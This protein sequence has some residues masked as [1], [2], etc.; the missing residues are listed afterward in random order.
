MNTIAWLIDSTLVCVVLF[1]LAHRFGFRARSKSAFLPISRIVALSP[2]ILLTSMI[3]GSFGAPVLFVCLWMLNRMCTV[4][5]AWLKD[6]S[7]WLFA[8]GSIITGYFML[9]CWIGIGNW[10]AGRTHT[11]G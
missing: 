6:L 1:A 8:L 10:R 7:L 2:L 11:H 3:A 4:P 9:F 5:D